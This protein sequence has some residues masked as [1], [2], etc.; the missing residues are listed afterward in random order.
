MTTTVTWQ[1]G[2]GT[3]DCSLR[4]QVAEDFDL[5]GPAARVGDYNANN[6]DDEAGFRFTNVA[7]PKNATIVSAYLWIKAWDIYGYPAPIAY[8]KGEAAD[9][10]ITFSTASD[11]KARPRTTAY[12]NWQPPS[13][14]DG[15]WYP[16]PNLKN[17]LQEI[18]DRNNWESGNALVLFWYEADGYVGRQ[19]E[20]DFYTYN[21]NPNDAAKLEV[22]WVVPHTTPLQT[23]STFKRGRGKGTFTVGRAKA[24]F[25]SAT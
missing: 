19:C 20:I 11:Y 18:I 17:I 13:W 8:V 2:Q 9:N 5:N 3:D 22:T 16:S 6:Y 24:F 7:I 15:T 21:F 23:K 1:V 25:T 14:V 12:V 10:P 4:K